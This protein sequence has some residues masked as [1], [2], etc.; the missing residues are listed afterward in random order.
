MVALFHLSVR[1]F[2]ACVVRFNRLGD[3]GA[4]GVAALEILALRAYR[5]GDIT[6]SQAESRSESSQGCYQHG[7]DD[8]ND[9]L[10]A[11]S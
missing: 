6:G 11:H 4:G 1:Q 7:D 2:F 9:L 5:T 10:L 3:D 8:F